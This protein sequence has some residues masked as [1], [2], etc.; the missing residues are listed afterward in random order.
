MKANSRMRRR[1]IVTLSTLLTIARCLGQSPTPVSVSLRCIGR[2][3]FPTGFWISDADPHFRHRADT[4]FWLSADKVATTFFKEY[5]CRS[6]ANSGVRYAVAAFDLAGKTIATHE[7]TSMADATFYA[8]GALGAFWVRYRDRVDVLSEDFAVVGQ[9]PLPKR[10]TLIWSKSGRGAAVQ[11]GTTILLYDMANLAAAAS[12]AGPADTRAVD[13]HRDAVLLNSLP[14]QPC[15]VRIVQAT[16]EHS[17]NVNSVTD[18]ASGRCAS[19]F[20]LLSADAVLVIEPG[21]RI[22]KIVHR[23]AAVEAIPAQGE[24]IGIADSGR[25]AFQS[26][27]PNSLAQKLDMDFGGHKEVSIYDPS[28]KAIV[29]QTKIGGQA[30]AALSPAGT[31]LL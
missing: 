13:V 27:Y 24:L 14:N 10:S 21:Q 26:F 28:T 1:L 22:R 15:S 25:L 31:T 16:K 18:E 4:L 6:G 5:C 23:D 30:G 29:F 7:W 19:G 20:A 2:P 17:W 11:A 3:Q 12:V 9:I 8:G